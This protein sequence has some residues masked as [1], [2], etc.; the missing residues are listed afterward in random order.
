MGLSWAHHSSCRKWTILF[1]YFI[2]F[3]IN[4]QEAILHVSNG[5]MSR[6]YCIVHNRSWTPLAPALDDAVS[7]LITFF[8]YQNLLSTVLLIPCSFFLF[9]RQHT[10][11]S[12]WPPRCCA[13]PQGL[14]QRH[15]RAKRWWWWGGGVTSAR[16][17]WLPKASALQCCS[18]RAQ[19]H[20]LDISISLHLVIGLNR[21][22]FDFTI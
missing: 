11:W 19:N 16:K 8:L 21:R 12:I 18:S 5:D 15:W 4:G 3:Q 6:E 1:I 22:M 20:W 17:L 9:S 7:S 13:M 14:I 2:Y 10:H